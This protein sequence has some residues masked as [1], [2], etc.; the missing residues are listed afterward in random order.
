MIESKLEDNQKLKYFGLATKFQISEDISIEYRGQLENLNADMWAITRKLS[1]CY[2]NKAHKWEW[3]RI[4]SGRTESFIARTRY[5]LNQAFE[6]VNS[7]EFKKY[8]S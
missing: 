8:L 7:S 5:P 6:I 4:P 1:L 2:N 3:E